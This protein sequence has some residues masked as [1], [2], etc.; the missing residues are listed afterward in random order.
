MPYFFFPPPLPCGGAPPPCGAAPPVLG[1]EPPPAGCPAGA[2]SG[3]FLP[4]CCG[5][6]EPCPAPFPA[7][8]APSASASPPRGPTLAYTDAVTCVGTVRCGS[9]RKVPV[10]FTYR[11]PGRWPGAGPTRCST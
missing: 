3:F 1:G 11:P 8:A 6:P 9:G 4:F 5:C 7:P 10:A 2:V